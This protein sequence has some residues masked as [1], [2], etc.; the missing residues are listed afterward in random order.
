MDCNEIHEQDVLEHYLLGELNDSQ[1]DAFEQHYF[2]CKD[3]FEDL[4]VARAI[5]EFVPRQPG[6]SNSKRAPHSSSL[7]S[8]WVPAIAIICLGFVALVGTWQYQK[9]RNESMNQPSQTINAGTNNTRLPKTDTSASIIELA[10]IEPPPYSPVVL[11]GLQDESLQAFH[12]AMRHYIRKDYASAIPGLRNAVRMNSQAAGATFYL[13]AC[14]LLTNQTDSAIQAFATT[15]SLDDS[16]YAE[17][18]HFYLSKAYLQKADL[19][20]AQIELERTVRFHG[21]RE[22]QARKLEQ[23]LTEL[24]GTKQ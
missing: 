15:I 14:Y 23:Q 20:N 17:Q 22:A 10:R 9:L 5:Q 6:L 13:G 1:Q 2:E 19:P 16:N 21:D 3:C 4:Q 12:D 24:T 8:A 18:A 7:H 11:R